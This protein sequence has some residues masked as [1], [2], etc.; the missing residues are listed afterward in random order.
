[1]GYLFGS[2]FYLSSFGI[3]A[4]YIPNNLNQIERKL[5]NGGFGFSFGFK[6]K[7][8]HLLLF[9]KYR[10]KGDNLELKLFSLS[11]KTLLIQYLNWNID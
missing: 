11:N 7:I 4:R 2:L 9:T 10:D 3:Y 6:L 8:K 5:V 1:M